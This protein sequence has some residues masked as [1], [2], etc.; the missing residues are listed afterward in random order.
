MNSLTETPPRTYESEIVPLREK[1]DAIDAEIIAILLSI[2]KLIKNR[3]LWNAY[4]HTTFLCEE[5]VSKYQGVFMTAFQNLRT[6]YETWLIYDRTELK[7][8][9]ITKYL[10][11]IV[12]L[13]DQRFEVVREVE[14]G[15]LKWEFHQPPM[16]EESRNHVLADRKEKWTQA[17]WEDAEII[18]P[19]IWN[20]IHK[21]ALKIEQEELK[22][23]ELKHWM[24][25]NGLLSEPY[26]EAWVLETQGNP[27]PAWY[28][29]VDTMQ[30]T[31]EGY[32]EIFQPSTQPQTP[33]VDNN[34]PKEFFH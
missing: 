21:I 13:L 23:A 10:E 27:K 20:P 4:I 11:K 3:E 14:V 15:A 6:A 28:E 25:E 33:I 5:P 2:Q 31:L 19:A 8:K 17:W 22:G 32:R 24:D 1:I 9:S 30:R 18:I 34:I 29:V 16:D 7:E 12:P 26:Y